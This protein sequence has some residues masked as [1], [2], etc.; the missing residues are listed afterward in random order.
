MRYRIISGAALLFILPAFVYAQSGGSYD[1]S[2]S[3]LD[4][5]GGTSRSGSYTLSSTIGQ[6]DAGSMGGGNYTLSGGFWGKEGPGGPS[7][8]VGAIYL[9]V[10]LRE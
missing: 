1:L 3:T 2:W 10:I 5:G 9:P 7:P 6:L 4:G 8:E